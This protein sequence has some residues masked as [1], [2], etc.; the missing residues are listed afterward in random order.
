MS[1]NTITMRTIYATEFQNTLYKEAVFPLLADTRF[2]N[3]LKDGA[4]VSW[5]Y[6]SD[7]AAGDL[8]T[9]DA[10]TVS[11]K[12]ITA[13][14]LTVNQK[15]FSGFFIPGSEKVQDHRP[16]QE[17]WAK[18]AMNVVMTKIDGDILNVVRAGA[19]NSLDNASFGGSAGD[20]ITASSN[21]AASIYA[22][23][24]R[25]LKNQNV[26]YNTN[27]KFTNKVALDGVERMPVAVIPA[28]LE[29]KLLLQIGFKDTGA[30]DEVM[31]SGYLGM[32]FGF[33]T[34]TSN[35]LPFS[36]RYTFSA[37][38]T[39]GKILTIGGS[40]TTIQTS[41]SD[42]VAINWVTSIGST[43]GN[44]LAETDAATSVGN[45]VDFLNDIYEGTTSAKYVGFTR[46]S[47]SPA[48]QRI[49]DGLSAV[50]NDDGSCVIT[51]K[52]LGHVAV[53]DDDSNSTIDRQMVHA[54]FGTSK[55]VGI[56]MQKTPEIEMSAGNL[57]SATSTTG[58]IGKHYVAWGL[59][60]R[61]VFKTQTYQM[62]NVKIDSSGFTSPNSVVL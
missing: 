11:G 48:Q 7:I 44:V 36:F 27:K 25:I 38:P 28:E 32:I 3:V 14:T 17:K 41:G 58:N 29:E 6:D 52:G 61:K 60:G 56:V 62:V 51:I 49:L 1:T 19:A 42:G 39:N 30:G 55:S 23:A 40:T 12:T 47:M 9:D 21:N 54:L 18:K 37:T 10:Y 59:Y 13:E 53:S 34:V 15:P 26:L 20:P 5:D 43:A 16:T 2:E 22:A 4:T 35:S 46:A 31:K 57:L 45:L 24:R 33:N 50:D 8:G